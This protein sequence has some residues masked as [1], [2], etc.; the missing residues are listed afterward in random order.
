MQQR[1]PGYAFAL[2]TEQDAVAALV[3][4]FGADRGADAW[5][6]ACRAALLRDG[7]VRPDELERAAGAL[8]TQ[9]P[10]FAAIA[11]SIVIRIRT[12]H[13]LNAKRAAIRAMGA[14]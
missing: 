6:V 3:R 2:P 13:R 9:G 5:A 8:A 10:A 4:V 12:H 1:I 14:S 11:R 7:A